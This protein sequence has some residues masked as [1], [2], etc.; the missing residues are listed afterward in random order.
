[1]CS[2][3]SACTDVRVLAERSGLLVI[4]VYGYDPLEFHLSADDLPRWITTEV[5]RDLRDAGNA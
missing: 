3:R 1:M 4:S 2:L 5:L